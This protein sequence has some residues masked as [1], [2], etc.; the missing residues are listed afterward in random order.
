[1]RICTVVSNTVHE[2]LLML[3]TPHSVQCERHIDFE[4]PYHC[5]HGR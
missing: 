4:T 1:M 2:H 3:M 5:I